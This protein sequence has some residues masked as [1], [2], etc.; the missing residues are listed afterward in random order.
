MSSLAPS[1]NNLI[2]SHQQFLDD[3]LMLGES[4][5]KDAKAIILILQKYEAASEQKVSLP[6]TIIFFFNTSANR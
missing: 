6:K 4:F 3:S 1:S 2:C 5:I